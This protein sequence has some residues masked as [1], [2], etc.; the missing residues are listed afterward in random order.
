MPSSVVPEDLSRGL[1]ALSARAKTH[2]RFTLA[3]RHPGT[4]SWTEV[5]ANPGPLRLPPKRSALPSGR[6]VYLE[7]GGDGSDELRLGLLWGLA[8]PLGFV[9][10][11]RY[12]ELGET[13]AVFHFWGPWRLLEDNLLQAGRGEA[14]WPSLCA[15]GQCLAGTWDDP[16]A[17]IRL[18]QAH[19]HRVGHPCGPVDGVLGTATNRA[20]AAASLGNLSVAEALTQLEI[21]AQAA[22]STRAPKRGRLE[23]DTP[24]T[25]HATGG[26]RAVRTPHGYALT[27]TGEGR[28][29]LD[30]G[31]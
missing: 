24:T 1:A 14:I 6:E 17:K 9:P 5:G 21:R 25:A 4:L 23:L 11:Q 20:L 31:V 18:I 2:S 3:I 10:W 19:L 13:S 16:D 15:A 28:L 27:V 22:P 26:V 30:V 7:L 8:V 29:I 12:P